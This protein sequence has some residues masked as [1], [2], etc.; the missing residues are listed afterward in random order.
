MSSKYGVVQPASPQTYA[1]GFTTTELPTELVCRRARGSVRQ[2]S[3]SKMS[4]YSW[5]ART[6][7]T[8]I[9]QKP[10]MLVRACCAAF[11]PLNVPAMCALEAL[12]AQTRKTV[13][14]ATGVAP[15]G[16][17]P[18]GVVMTRKSPRGGGPPHMPRAL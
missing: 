1:S 10:W 8:W 17:L 13:P 15:S 12:G 5:P 14:P 6:P 9:S 16:C 11:Q 7:G 4:L 18:S 2:R 3:P